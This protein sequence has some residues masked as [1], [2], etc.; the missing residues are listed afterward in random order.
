MLNK[1]GFTLIEILLVLALMTVVAAIMIPISV[2]YQQRNN[3]DVAQ[4]IFVQNIRRAQQLSMSG[5][6][7][8]HWGVKV[9]PGDIVIYK[10]ND[11]AS[12]DTSYDEKF[13]FIISPAII[14]SGTTEYNF[15]PV[16]GIPSPTTGTVFFTDNAY[17]K[18]VSVNEKGI[19]YY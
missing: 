10:G 15:S 8:S 13:D 6:L 2:D 5:E 19:V 9:I 4:N 17:S 7:D 18:Q 3:L 14:S 16:T 11:Y 1:R 12:R